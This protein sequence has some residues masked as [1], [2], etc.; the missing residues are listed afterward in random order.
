M[1]RFV[2]RLQRVLDVRT[3]QEQVKRIELFRLTEELADKRSELLMRQ[4]ILQDVISGVARTQSP[5]RVSAQEFCLRHAATN[6]EQIR[7]LRQEIA[8]LETRQ[9]EKTAE[10]LTIRRSKEGLE[11]LRAEARE[12]FLRECDRLE[13]K[14]LDDKTTSAFARREPV[15][16]RCEM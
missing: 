11:R 14:D 7:R 15:E 6:D 1:K 10:L 5:T 13:Q 12:R 9:R 8:G 16:D 2:W 3:K 4:R